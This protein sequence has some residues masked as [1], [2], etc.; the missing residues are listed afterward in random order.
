MFSFA[1]MICSPNMPG[2]IPINWTHTT[3]LFL[4]YIQ[5]RPCLSEPFS[6]HLWITSYLLQ[7]SVQA[8]DKQRHFEDKSEYCRFPRV[9]FLSRG[10]SISF[11]VLWTISTDPFFKWIKQISLSYSFQTKGEDM[12]LF[13]LYQSKGTL[14]PIK[15]QSLMQLWTTNLTV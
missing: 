11:I 2:Y 8:D 1:F 3:Y 13:D 5:L 12:P 10:K 14:L 4:T 7:T 15:S 6:V 9:R